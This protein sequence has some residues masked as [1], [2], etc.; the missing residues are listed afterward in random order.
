MQGASQSSG[1]AGSEAV[2]PATVNE[3][4]ANRVLVRRTDQSDTQAPCHGKRQTSERI[5][6]TLCVVTGNQ[7]NEYSSG[8]WLRLVLSR[9]N[10]LFGIRCSR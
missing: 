4:S 1:C 7:C 6:C 2:G 9:L 3:L 8:P 10:T 5:I